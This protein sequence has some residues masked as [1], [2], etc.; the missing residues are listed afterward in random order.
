MTCRV[1][2]M[3]YTGSGEL[4]KEQH[5]LPSGVYALHRRHACI[6]KALYT[7][8]VCDEVAPESVEKGLLALVQAVCVCVYMCV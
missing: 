2:Y 5:D 1:V 3:H 8:A 7:C 4:I 6:F